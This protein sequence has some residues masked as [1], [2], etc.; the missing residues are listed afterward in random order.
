[1]RA[2]TLIF[3]AFLICK[4]GI[5]QVITGKVTEEDGKTP[6]PFATIYFN[7]TFVGTSSNQNGYF[8]LDISNSASM[9]L[10]ISAIGYYSVT[11]TNYSNLNSLV[12][13]LKAKNYE[14]EDAVI[15][16][17]SLA[18]KRK[19]NLKLFR[20]EFLGI[21]DNARKCN[22]LNEEDITFNYYSDKDT[23]KA[24]ALKPIIIENKALGYKVTYYLDKFEYYK[25]QEAT[26][27][28]GNIIFNEDYTDSEIKDQYYKIK[29]KEA[30]LGS[31]MHFFRALW[32]RNMQS[33]G[34]YVQDPSY[35]LLKDKHIVFIDD[36]GNRFLKF[37]K[38]IYIEFNKHKSIIKFIE[39][40]VYF[41]GNGFFNPG[42]LWEGEMSKHRVAEWLPYEYSIGK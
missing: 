19:R 34:F 36:Q 38:D 28:C 27:F 7:G 8:E 9:P 10:T 33:S 23:I 12:V 11:I 21:T 5:G 1:M 37:D 4:T 20:E 24:Y 16:A 35:R 18:R 42:L 29:R 40:K 6:V 13:K 31:R 26:F 15:N 22:I 39:D 25:K 3:F 32:N 30:Y 2:I 41:E 17:K 14:I